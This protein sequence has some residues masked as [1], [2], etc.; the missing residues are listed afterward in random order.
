MTTTNQRA[1]EELEAEASRYRASLAPYSSPA[2]RE[3]TERKIAALD[4]AIATL[5]TPGWRPISEAPRDGTAVLLYGGGGCFGWMPPANM[6]NFPTSICY[7]DDRKAAWIEATGEQYERHNDPT[8]F[9]HLPP[10][11]G[12]G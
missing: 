6:E 11:P 2:Y 5:R 7:W 8:H 12:E 4:L 3:V 9:R 1:V 10:A